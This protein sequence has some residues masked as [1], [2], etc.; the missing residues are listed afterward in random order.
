MKT[1]QIDLVSDGKLGMF[2][3]IFD[4]LREGVNVIDEKGVLIFV[5]RASADYARSTVE[6]MIGQHISRFYPK[7]ALLEVIQTGKAQLDVKTVHDDGRTYI[8]NAVPLIMDGQVKGGVA[9]F[10]DITEIE[11]LSKKMEYL[12]MELT[13]SQINNSFDLVIGKNG[14]LR[15]TILRAQRAI[16]ALGGPRHSV[17]VGESGTGKTLL[18]K[19]MYYFAKKIKVLSADA[20][21]IEVNCAQ[22][23]NPDIAA[24][25]IF[26]SEKGAFTGA[27]EK[28][29]LLEL[30]DGGMLFLDEAHALEQYQTMLLKAIESGKMRR[31][32]GRKEIDINVIIVAASTKN[33]KNVFLPELYQRLAQYEIKLPPLR[34]RPLQEKE[35]L[36][37]YCACTYEEKAFQ[38]YGIKLNIHFSD[39]AKGILLNAYYPR[40]IRQFRDVV[41]AG[42][43]S[44]VPLIN[45]INNAKEITA[46]VDV[47]HIPF[48]LLEAKEEDVPNLADTK[49]ISSAKVET[50]A[51]MVDTIIAQLKNK[52]LGPRKIA[53]ILK[54]QG[55]DIEYYQVAYKLKK[56][57]E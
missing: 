31:V 15:E 12:E 52:G 57:A 29:G 39:A 6:Q 28:K 50:T 17:I 42:I 14:S 34:D 46:T 16:G 51:E 35:Q 5:N 20:P 49:G 54:D 1:M 13:L 44:A 7:A 22:F 23:T 37:K 24:M 19:A 3:T 18:A 21:F 53:N 26:G 48:D 30:A 40:N 41:N 56:L 36:L 11:Q 45:D 9:T 4:N 47:E 2:E 8:V 55:I 27:V 33:L 38:R 25:E 32:G 10:R 43:D